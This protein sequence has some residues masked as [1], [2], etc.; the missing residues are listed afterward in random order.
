MEFELDEVGEEGED[1][2]D[3]GFWDGL[4]REGS[5]DGG[6]GWG[7]FQ[8]ADDDLARC[9][10]PRSAADVH[11]DRS[12]EETTRDDIPSTTDEAAPCAEDVELGVELARSCISTL[13]LE[14]LRLWQGVELVEVRRVQVDAEHRQLEDALDQLRRQLRYPALPTSNGTFNSH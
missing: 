1:F 4:V 5:D 10:G 11:L 2:G 12:V 3:E 8:V 13:E 14:L 9:I 7:L 6:V